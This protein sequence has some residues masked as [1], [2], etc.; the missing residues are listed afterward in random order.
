MQSQQSQEDGVGWQWA[1]GRLQFFPKQLKQ[2]NMSIFPKETIVSIAES[3]GIPLNDEV[4]QTLLQD[5]EYRLR[6]IIH[7]SVKFMRHSHRTKLTPKY[8]KLTK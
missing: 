8:R 2:L 3:L 6:E 1:V 7:E 5:A 4:A